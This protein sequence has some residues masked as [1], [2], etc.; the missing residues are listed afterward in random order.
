MNKLCGKCKQRKPLIAFY[1]RSD[2]NG[3]R[4]SCKAC[5]DE[6]NKAHRLAHPRYYKIKRQDHH[7]KVKY[8]ISGEEYRRRI[9]QGYCDICKTTEAGG[10]HNK[11]HVDHNHQTGELRG[12]LCSRCNLMIGWLENNAHLIPAMESYLKKWTKSLKAVA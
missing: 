6:K 7:A 9:S 4:A 5:V 12:I 3:Y 2:T 11:W 1:K 8:G 10:R